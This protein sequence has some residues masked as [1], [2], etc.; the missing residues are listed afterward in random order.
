L[1]S[2]ERSRRIFCRSFR[3]A[4][5][6]KRPATPWAGRFDENAAE[7]QKNAHGV[8]F[9][10]CARASKATNGADP[11]INP[12]ALQLPADAARRYPAR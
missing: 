5:P 10:T 9:S 1:E 11:G 12:A 7:V 4:I 3:I 6:A 8:G 2:T